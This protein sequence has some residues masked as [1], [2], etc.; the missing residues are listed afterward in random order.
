MNESPCR[1]Y[2]SI[3]V[4]QCDVCFLR[5]EVSGAYSPARAKFSLGAQGDRTPRRDGYAHHPC[6]TP[7][8]LRSVQP[9]RL[10][11]A[12]DPGLDRVGQGWPGVDQLFKVRVLD[13]GLRGRCAGLCAGRFGNRRF[14]R[15]IVGAFESTGS[16]VAGPSSVF[17][18]SGLS[19][20]TRPRLHSGMA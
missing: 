8:A 20:T 2:L 4:H 13:C 11:H 18:Q 17:R 9:H 15:E 10:D 16:R 12:R 6:D 7:A 3:V 19:G 5:L 14:L 1:L